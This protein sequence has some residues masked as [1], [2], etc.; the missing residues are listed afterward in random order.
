[1]PAQFENLSDDLIWEVTRSQ[2]AFLVKRKGAGGVQFSRDPLNLLNKHSRKYSG[3]ANSQAIGVQ[4]DSNTIALTTKLPKQ[5]SRPAKNYHVS[6][7]S[8][9]TPTRKLYVGIVNSTAKKGYRADLRQAAVARASAVRRS[10]RELTRK[11]PVRKPRGKKAQKAA[12][13]SS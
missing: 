7:F 13:E 4:A 5:A 11:E 6:S 3:Y 9:S 12:E 1:M 10:Q 8:S 2:N